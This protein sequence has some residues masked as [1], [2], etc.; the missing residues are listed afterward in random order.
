M[1][2]LE[3][4]LA[5]GTCFV[6]GAGVALA[7][8]PGASKSPTLASPSLGKTITEAEIKAWDIDAAP[9]GKGLP[10]GSGTPTQGAK[11]YSEKCAAC[12]KPDG[13]GGGSPGAARSLAARR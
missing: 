6:I 7:Q 4:A 2:T 11:V 12:H 1:S 13:T 10:A 9:S 8:S 5:I 3:V